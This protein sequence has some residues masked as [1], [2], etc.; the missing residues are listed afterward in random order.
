MKNTHEKKAIDFHQLALAGTLHYLDPELLTAD[1]LLK[2]NDFDETAI[3][4]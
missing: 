2:K 3:H 1:N 4:I